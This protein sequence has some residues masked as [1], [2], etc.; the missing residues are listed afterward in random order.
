MGRFGKF[1]AQGVV[2]LVVGVGGMSAFVPA[3]HAVDGCTAEVE[4]LNDQGQVV[5]DAFVP[6]TGGMQNGY[7][8]LYDTH[9]NYLGSVTN[10]G[11]GDPPLVP[12][13]PSS[14]SGGGSSSHSSSSSSGGTN[15]GPAT[16]PGAKPTKPATVRRA[17]GS[18]S[19]STVSR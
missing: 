9:G 10:G 7:A 17:G 11:Y 5:S 2:A 3:A 8:Y 19:T 18:S 6:C 16:G 4:T 1:V 13:S 12:L 15:H 14:H